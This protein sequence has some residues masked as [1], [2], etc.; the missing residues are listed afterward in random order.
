MNRLSRVFCVLLIVFIA[1][2]SYFFIN[3]LA[4]NKREYKMYE[5][6][7]LIVKR[8]GIYDLDNIKKINSDVIGWIEVEGTNINYPV[9]QNGDFYLNKNIY[10]NYSKHGTPYLAHYCDCEKS[11]NLLIYGSEMNDNMIFSQLKKYKNYNFYLKHKYIKLYTI[12]KGVTIENN[13]EIMTV[14][15]I[16][17][18]FNNRFKYYKCSDFYN[19]KEYKEFEDI[20]RKLEFYYTGV[21][22]THKDKYITLLTYKH[23]LE[24]IKLVLIA[25]RV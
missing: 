9:M 21:V 6:L 16:L 25:K 15:E 12:E 23:S 14:F 11:D 2:S 4:E 7:Q 13:Y 8:D 20:Y 19:Y 22:G 1:I 3:K 24:N 10:K 18:G 5:N 17:D